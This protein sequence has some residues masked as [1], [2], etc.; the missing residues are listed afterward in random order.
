MN[1]MSNKVTKAI[2]LARVSSKEQKIAILLK[3]QNTICRNILPV[4]A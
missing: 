2:I 4:K 1:N 3:S